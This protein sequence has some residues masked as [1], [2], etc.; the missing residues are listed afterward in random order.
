M[1]TGANVR[2]I[3]ADIRNALRN[4][5]PP[6]YNKPSAAAPS[7]PWEKTLNM[8]TIMTPT[9]PQTTIFGII[10]RTLVHLP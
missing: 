7:T 9:I 5:D 8:A 6:R 10:P 1:N 4:F 3:I 2:F